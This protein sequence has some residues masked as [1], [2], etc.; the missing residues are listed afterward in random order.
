MP[1]RSKKITSVIGRSSQW[2]GGQFDDDPEPALG[3]RAVARVA[4]LDRAIPVVTAKGVERVARDGGA[5]AQVE[6]GKIRIDSGAFGKNLALRPGDRVTVRVGERRTQLPLGLSVLERARE[7]AMLRAL[8]LTRGQLRRLLATEAVLLS[9]VATALGTVIGLGFAW[10]GYETLVTR[11]LSEATM[12]IPWTSLGLVVL[13]AALAGL[14]AAVLPA[15]RAAR[16]T[17]AAGLS[18]D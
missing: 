18:L 14:L 12:R 2:R 13:A 6:L 5:F 9:V 10:V 4:G 17:P 3:A 11:A 15:R 1:S 7:H 16:V 8:G